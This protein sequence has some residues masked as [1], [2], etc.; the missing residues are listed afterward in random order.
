MP[1]AA[2][3]LV[4]TQDADGAWR[5]F[6]SPFTEATDKAYETHVSWGLFEAARLE[7][8]S[9]YAEAALRNVNWALGLQTA[10]GWFENCCLSDQHRPLTHTLGYV[11]RGI[12]EA[13]RFTNDERFLAAAIKTAEGL[14][15]AS[16][17]DGSLPGRLDRDWNGTV[18]WSCLTGN[19]QIAAS[20]FLLFEYTAE[21]AY[22]NAALAANKFVRRTVKLDDAEPETLGAIKGSFPISG[23]YSAY[24]YPNWATKFF[25]DSHL[26]EE[27]MMAGS[28]V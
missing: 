13:Y 17:N 9:G 21:K 14:L 5:K 7:P 3:W 18:S 23:D 2:E 20:W 12:I 15:K 26:M 22:L 27:S 4:N 25:L 10:N 8:E 11:L 1:G 16:R 19:L 24:E 6:R 28:T